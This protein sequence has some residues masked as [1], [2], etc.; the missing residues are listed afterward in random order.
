MRHEMGIRLWRWGNAVS[1]AGVVLFLCLCTPAALLYPGGTLADRNTAGY[2]FSENFLSDLGRTVSWSGDANTGAAILFNT[3]VVVLGLS[4]VPFFLFLPLHAP[5]RSQVLWVAAAFGVVSALALVAIGLT[6][7]DVC[8]GPHHTALF[9]WVIFL[10]VAVIL[11]F[12]AL[13][14]SDECSSLFAVASLALVCVFCLYAIQGAAFVVASRWGS[15]SETLTGLVTMQKYVVLSTMGWYLVFSVRMVCTTD[16]NLP[17]RTPTL[18]YSAEA[19]E[20]WLR[21]RNWRVQRPT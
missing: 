2:S 16:L 17:N 7:Y 13:F 5:D 18:D 1:C 4:I 11:H 19:Y 8:F 12:W 6:P 21:G 14:T 20:Q 3:A 10:S 9:L 15:G